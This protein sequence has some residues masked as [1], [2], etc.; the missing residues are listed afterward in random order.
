MAEHYPIYTCTLRNAIFMC[1]IH[2]DTYL[3]G[4]DGTLGCI[5]SSKYDKKIKNKCY[6]YIIIMQT[7]IESFEQ[8]SRA[9]PRG[10]TWKSTGTS[11]EGTRI[12]SHHVC[13]RLNIIYICGIYTYLIQ[14]A[15]SVS[16]VIVAYIKYS[17][18]CVL[19]F[20]LR[21]RHN[22]CKEALLSINK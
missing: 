13:P 9:K 7:E 11:G 17:K 22:L 5:S 4:F 12:M 2:M 3:A 20:I 10:Y 14:R 19:E 18:P 8:G 16:H 6:I 15:N 1:H 21:R